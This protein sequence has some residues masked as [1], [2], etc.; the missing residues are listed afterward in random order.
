MKR[1]SD[2]PI[3]RYLT[4]DKFLSLLQARKL[5]FSRS[6]TFD[7]RWEGFSHALP[8]SRK[9]SGGTTAAIEAYLDGVRLHDNWMRGSMKRVVFV[10]CWSACPDESIPL[11]R[12]FAPGESGVAI[13]STI[14]KFL[15]HVDMKSHFAVYYT[16]HVKYYD[17]KP[18]ADFDYSKELSASL[19]TVCQINLRKR[20]C[21]E[22]EEEWRAVGI[23][24]SH[25]K[26]KGVL[27]PVDLNSLVDRVVVSP[28]ASRAFLDT[29]RSV[30]IKSGLGVQPERS[31]LERRLP[32]RPQPISK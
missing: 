19:E 30:A 13:R 24:K 29:I 27:V 2:H 9:M 26:G 25:H 7:D 23:G 22:Y 18:T 15:K 32:R 1:N 16:D 8:A 21:F 14:P 28:L 10:S 11:W 3:W 31:T 6:D 20:R 12:I 4:L 5:W 17:G